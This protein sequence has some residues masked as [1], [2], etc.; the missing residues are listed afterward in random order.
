MDIL[1]QAAGG[2]DNPAGVAYAAKVEL[3]EHTSDGRDTRTSDRSARLVV[4]PAP[5]HSAPFGEMATCGLFPVENCMFWPRPRVVAR[6]GTAVIR[7]PDMLEL[8]L[9]G[10]RNN[11]GVL[12]TVLCLIVTNLHLH[13]HDFSNAVPCKTSRERTV[14]LQAHRRRGQ[15]GR[16]NW[17]RFGPLVDFWLPHPRILHPY[18]NVR[19]D[20]KHPR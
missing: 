20:A 5:P 3:R 8:T 15:R 1:D 13:A 19:F 17:E 7:S 6:C 18:S 9:R 10:T 11:K 16:I 12:W 2:Q 14:A 4:A